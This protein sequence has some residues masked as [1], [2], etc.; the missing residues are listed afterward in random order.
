MRQ[1]A[2]ELIIND[3]GKSFQ[4]FFQFASFNTNKVADLRAC[5]LGN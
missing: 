2:V 5:G 3:Y 1:K 4:L